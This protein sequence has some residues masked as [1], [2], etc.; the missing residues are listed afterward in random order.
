M[1]T[2]IWRKLT[3]DIRSQYLQFILIWAV[4]TLCALLLMVSLLVMGSANDPWKRIFNQT[5]GPHVWIVTR[6]QDLDFSKLLNDPEVTQSTG[7]MLALAEN[8]LIIADE[9]RP[10]FL[11][12][13]L[14]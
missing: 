2:V 6:H 12:V 9:K 3:A 10:M 5:N 8:P 13:L 1:I 11:L 4:L 14:C 7:T